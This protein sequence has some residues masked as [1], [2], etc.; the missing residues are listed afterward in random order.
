MEQPFHCIVFNYTVFYFQ[1]AL[2]CCIVFKSLRRQYNALYCIILKFH[3][4]RFLQNI[5]LGFHN[6]TAG[7]AIF[8]S[9]FSIQI[10]DRLTQFKDKM[11]HCASGGGSKF[12]SLSLV[13]FYPILI[14][15]TFLYLEN[16]QSQTIWTLF[17]YKLLSGAN[18]STPRVHTL[19]KIY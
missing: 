10:T 18:L 19:I 7:L 11:R 12:R 6:C 5:E 16:G 14:Q 13:R 8:L 9:A 3:Y 4:S 2:K 1:V 15:I 17:T